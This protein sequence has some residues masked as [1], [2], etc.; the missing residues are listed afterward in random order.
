MAGAAILAGVAAL[1]VGAGK[2]QI[3][4][5]RASAA[6]LAVAVPEARIVIAPAMTASPLID[7]AAASSALVLGPGMETGRAQRRLASRLLQ[8]AAGVPAVIDAGAL[9]LSNEASAFAR[10]AGGRI[11]LTLHAGEMAAILDRDKDVIRADPLGAARE[12]ATMFQSVIVMKGATTFVVSPDGTAWR[13]DGGVVGLGTSGSGDVLAGAIGGFLARG[14]PPVDAALLGR[15]RSRFGRGGPRRRRRSAG[16][17]GARVAGPAPIHPRSAGRDFRRPGL[18]MNSAL[19]TL[20][21]RPAPEVAARLIGAGLMV[22]GVGGTIVETEAYAA[23]DPASHSFRGLTPRNAPMFGPIGRAYV[24]RIYGRHWCLNVVCDAA[25][26]G[27]AVL[28]RALE[29]VWNPEVMTQRRGPV[30]TRDLCAG[31]GRLCQ[32]LGVTGD[33][34]HRPMAAAPFTIELREPEPVVAGPRIG[35]RQGVETPWRFARAG[36]PSLSRPTVGV[37]A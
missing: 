27:S 11:V 18:T 22:D 2:L 24:Y 31:P 29:P 7:H 4:A 14:A 37:V 13:H 36:S 23:H 20:W 10:V 15:L 26:P 1:K 3:R 6:A 21:A 16:V 17:P 32:A 35:I 33:L 34:N 30:P 5:D 25:T 8:A 9:P 19:A 12:A 28:I